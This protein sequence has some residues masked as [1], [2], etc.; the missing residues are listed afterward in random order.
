MD[1]DGAVRFA[2]AAGAL[3]VTVVGAEPSMPNRARVEELVD[4]QVVEIKRI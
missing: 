4:S 2:N 3:A 1:L